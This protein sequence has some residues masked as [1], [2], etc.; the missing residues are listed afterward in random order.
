MLYACA[1][2]DGKGETVFTSNPEKVFEIHLGTSQGTVMTEIGAPH[3]VV[4]SNS[5]YNYWEY[6]FEIKDNQAYI[7]ERGK[8]YGCD[9][10]RLFFDEQKKLIDVVKTSSSL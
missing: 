8:L 4:L 3:N 9:A 2:F 6:C 7:T 1:G 10:M 5:G